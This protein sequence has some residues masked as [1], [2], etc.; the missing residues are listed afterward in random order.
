MVCLTCGGLVFN[1]ILCGRGCGTRHPFCALC[2][3]RLGE[4]GP[5]FIPL[6]YYPPPALPDG[7]SNL[8]L[9]LFSKKIC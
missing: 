2:G 4:I 3:V 8:L 7:V 1:I 9:V 6:L 5:V